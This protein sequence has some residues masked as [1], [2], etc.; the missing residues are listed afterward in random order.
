VINESLVDV[1]FL[2][3]QKKNEPKRKVVAALFS[4]KV[5]GGAYVVLPENQEATIVRVFKVCAGSC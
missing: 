4:F 1:L 5:S 2:F 3:S